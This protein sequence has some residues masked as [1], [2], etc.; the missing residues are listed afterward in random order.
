MKS[1]GL[2][3]RFTSRTV[4]ESSVTTG[5]YHT[6]FPCHP[7][8][9]NFAF[10]PILGWIAP[11]Y[12]TLAFNQVMCHQVGDMDYKLTSWGPRRSLRSPSFY[13]FE[14]GYMMVS[15]VVTWQLLFM[16]TIINHTRQYIRLY[17]RQNGQNV[18][19]HVG[20]TK[21]MTW[22][23]R[24]LKGFLINKKTGRRNAVCWSWCNRNDSKVIRNFPFFYR[25]TMTKRWNGH[26]S[27][28]IASRYWISHQPSIRT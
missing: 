2:T 25:A 15:G 18:Y 28:N 7:A 26:S 16:L 6:F 3:V 9:R 19:A 20:L 4:K 14:Y 11:P 12:S 5:R 27:W 8:W 10:I 17:P 24:L 13:I 22:R 1:I 21:V 23:P